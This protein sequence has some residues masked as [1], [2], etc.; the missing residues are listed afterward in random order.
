MNKVIKNIKRH[1]FRIPVIGSA[2]F[3]MTQSCSPS[4]NVTYTQSA[5]DLQS[6]NQIDLD[7]DSKDYRKNY[8]YTYHD[9]LNWTRGK[10]VYAQDMAYRH[11]KIREYAIFPNEKIE[12]PTKIQQY[13][14]NMT[15]LISK[16]SIGKNIVLN[17]Q[18]ENVVVYADSTQASITGGYYENR[19]ISNSLLGFGRS[20][21][22]LRKEVALNKNVTKE[23]LHA[24]HFMTLFEEY[25]HAKD[26]ITNGVSIKNDASQPKLT[27]LSALER[28]YNLEAAAKTNVIIGMHELKQQGYETLW[29]NA[30]NVEKEANSMI[31]YHMMNYYDKNI[32][33]QS[34]PQEKLD[35]ASK[36]YKNI[37][38]DPQFRNEYFKF[39]FQ[40]ID[41]DE[42][43]QFRTI[44]RNELER[45]GNI[46]GTNQNFIK[47]AYEMGVLESLPVYS[48]WQKTKITDMQK[49]I[50][51]KNK[52]FIVTR[53]LK[54]E[55]GGFIPVKE[56]SKKRSIPVIKN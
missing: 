15:D 25:V 42:N 33:D 36:I 20:L 27:P 18:K 22:G 54:T 32:S 37:L 44:T 7:K 1:L 40:N 9:S 26:F 34:T 2:L 50:Q 24:F 48:P 8:F 51:A 55:L 17:A 56:K 45:P 5:R 30:R 21:E 11:G 31:T 19:K 28:K 3:L 47:N 35:I 46:P 13:L 12:N 14:Q 29:N 41:Y 16:S 10:Q 43:S 53:F 49:E 38:Y 52:H 23:M 6:K 4:Q 39:C